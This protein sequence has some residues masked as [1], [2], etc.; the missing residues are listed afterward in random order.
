MIFYKNIYN[1]LIYENNPSEYLIYLKNNGLISYIPELQFL[2]GTPQD[3]QWHPEGD[4]WS[5]TLL[6]IEQ[7]S[8]FKD[9]FYYQ[10]DI[11]AFMLGAL[12]HDFGKPYTT[13]WEND[14]WR[15]PKHDLIGLIPTNNLLDKMGL[16]ASIKHKVN[17]YV[18]EH[19]H[20]MQLYKVRDKVRKQA[21]IKLQERI[22]IPD[23]VL[24][25]KADHYGRTTQDALDKEAPHCDWLLEKYKEL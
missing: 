24:L 13:Y 1:F 3:P 10:D 2:I 9:N 11:A 7:A 14:R 23:L 16:D 17:N 5:H 25:A 22:H 4:V 19:L 6:V 20:P 12:C 21:I 8:H 15:S 18:L